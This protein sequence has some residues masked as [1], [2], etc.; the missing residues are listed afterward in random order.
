MPRPDLDAIAANSPSSPD[1]AVQTRPVLLMVVT[2]HSD[3]HFQVVGALY[4]AHWTYML[5]KIWARCTDREIRLI[6]EDRLLY[7]HPRGLPGHRY[8]V[9]EHLPEGRRDLRHRS[10]SYWESKAKAIGSDVSDLVTAIFDGD[11]VLLQLRR[12]QQVVTL[13]EKYPARRARSSCRMVLRCR[14]RPTWQHR[15]CRLRHRPISRTRWCRPGS[16]RRRNRR[17][18]RER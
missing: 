12:V 11:D 3:S 16:C 14:L 2:V 17:R 10:R 9:E 13:L 15:R 5:Q 1:A 8:T 4:S 18:R 7:A 6:A